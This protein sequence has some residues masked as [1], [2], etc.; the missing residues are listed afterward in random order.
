MI[1]SC[2]A[3]DD[4]P[5]ALK[6]MASYIEQTPALK[7]VSTFSNGIAALKA[8]NESPV[9]LLFLDIRMNDLSGIELAKLLE[10]YKADGNLRII[11]TTAYDQYALEGYKVEALD[12][13]LKPFSY[14]DFLKAVNKAVKYYELIRKTGVDEVEKP[15]EI[16]SAEKSYIYVKVEYQLVRIATEEI[17]Y[18]ESDKDYI[19]IYI[20]NQP[21]PIVSLMSMKAIEEKLPKDKFMRIHRSFIVSLDKIKAATKGTIEVAGKTIPVTDQYREQFAAF[22]KS[23]Q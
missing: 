15:V 10:P 11:F 21:K 7:L 14:D 17:T 5:L 12:Y 22:F 13:L 20:E 4:E 19:K 2:I 8:I 1:L 18:L 3:V 16:P 23:W 6:M 9:D